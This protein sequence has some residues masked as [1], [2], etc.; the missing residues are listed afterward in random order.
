MI[1]SIP[2]H[3]SILFQITLIELIAQDKI[4]SNSRSRIL[5]GDCC[6][7]LS[8]L[9]QFPLKFDCA[10]YSQSRTTTII[11]ITIKSTNEIIGVIFCYDLQDDLITLLKFIAQNL[12]KIEQLYWIYFH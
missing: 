6:G 4:S 2:L 12:I 9:P 1:A 3:V 11:T 5:V 8:A 10:S 7:L